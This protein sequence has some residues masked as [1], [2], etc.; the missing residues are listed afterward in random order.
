MDDDYLLLK[1]ALEE[2]KALAD[3]EYLNLFHCIFELSQTNLL[4]VTK[5]RKGRRNSYVNK[6]KHLKLCIDVKGIS[7]EKKLLFCSAK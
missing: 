4:V 6:L 1:M 3:I 7:Y 5:E 2:P